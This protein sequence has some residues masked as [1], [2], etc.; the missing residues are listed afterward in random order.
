MSNVNK[1]LILRE[2]L[3]IQR[4]IMANQSTFLAFLRTALYFMV[5]GLSIQSLL[6]IK[7]GYWLEWLFF[8]AAIV[9][10]ITGVINYLRHR[11]KIRISEK[12]IGDFK[13]EYLSE[14]DL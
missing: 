9:I 6:K 11:K 4:T 14:L 2:K 12:H 3:A 13:M 10:F 5:A 1:D 7:Q 8:T